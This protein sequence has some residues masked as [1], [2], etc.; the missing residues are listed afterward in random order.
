MITN[1]IKMLLPFIVW[2]GGPA[3]IRCNLV[4]DE[5]HNSLLSLHNG[6][7]AFDGG[8]RIF[9]IRPEALQTL[10]EWN[11]QNGWRSAYKELIRDTLIFFAEDVFG[12]QF[13]FDDGSVIY[14]DVENG[15]ATPFAK[16]FSEWLSIILEDPVDTLQLMLYKNWLAKGERLEPSEHLCPVHP[17]IVKADPPLK[18]LYRVKSMEDMIYKGNFA[19]QIKDVP[20]G[21]Q[22]KMRVT[23]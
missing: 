13:A 4:R 14:F 23:E 17:F 22:I 9:G 8:L 15:R 2:S 12:N 21:A 20:D 11:E 3:K 16:S 10:Q 1:E 6:L 19:Y 18:E 5:D 7:T